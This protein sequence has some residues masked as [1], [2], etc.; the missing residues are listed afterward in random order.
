MRKKHF[1]IAVLIFLCTGFFSYGQNVQ[2]NYSEKIESDTPSQLSL[3]LDNKTYLKIDIQA[4][5]SSKEIAVLSFYRAQKGVVTKYEMDLPIG[6]SGIKLSKKNNITIEVMMKQQQ[7]SVMLA[8]AVDG[9]VRNIMIPKNYSIP[10]PKGQICSYIPMET[11]LDQ[12]V[13]INDE[14]PIFAITG[15]ICSNF[16]LQGKFIQAQDFC[17]LRDKHIHPK[18]WIS[19][20]GVHDYCFYTIKFQ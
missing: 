16:D 12:L 3:A 18:E 20:E 6:F 14:F 19:I 9:R 7:D 2:V 5:L 11:F 13:T 17:G 1:I 15:G 10:F 8:F 4:D